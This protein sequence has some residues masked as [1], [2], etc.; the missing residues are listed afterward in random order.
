[1]WLVQEYFKAENSFIGGWY[2]ND[3]TICDDL[4]NYFEY[5]NIKSNTSNPIIDNAITN[6]KDLNIDP[7]VLIVQRYIKQLDE[8]LVS[9]IS[10]Y[11][12][13]NSID[14]FMVE[15]GILRRYNNVNAKNEWT[16]GRCNSDLPMVARHLSFTT[17]LNNIQDGGEIEFYHQ[18][19]N[20]KPKKG[21]TLIWPSDWTHVHRQNL[22]DIETK[23][24]ITGHYVLFQFL[25]K[26]DESNLSMDKNLNRI[27]T[28][29]T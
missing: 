16:I 5:E 25:N 11:P 24:V 9:Y 6:S 4:I 20:I 23:Y 7:N 29:N 14:P 13:C 12:F 22:S 27:A 2:V 21:L 1:M 8:A 26:S 18:K 17:F 3:K 28:F 15:A 19:L 10:L